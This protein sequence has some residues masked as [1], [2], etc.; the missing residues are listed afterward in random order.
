[1]EEV[2]PFIQAR[3]YIAG[4]FACV[5]SLFTSKTNK[6]L[7][8]QCEAYHVHSMISFIVTPGKSMHT[9]L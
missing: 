9:H 7:T 2:Q 4:W 8:P 3:V 6:P 5:E 1:M